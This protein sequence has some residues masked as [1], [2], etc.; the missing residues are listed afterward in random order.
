[1][2]SFQAIVLDKSIAGSL[3]EI[4]NAFLPAAARE[5]I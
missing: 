5:T 2:P 1:M 3:A 4:P